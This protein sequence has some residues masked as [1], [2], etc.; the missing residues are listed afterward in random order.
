MQSV[1]ALAVQLDVLEIVLGDD[2]G[3]RRFVL[4]IDLEKFHLIGREIEEIHQ[5]EIVHAV[6]VVDQ[7]DVDYFQ[8]IVAHVERVKGEIL[9]KVERLQ[10]AVAQIDDVDV[11]KLQCRVVEIDGEVAQCRVCHGETLQMRVV[12]AWTQD[13]LIEVD[14]LAEINECQALVDVQ[15]NVVD[16]V[17]LSSFDPLKVRTR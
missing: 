2:D 6:P 17:V 13:H 15:V 11:K 12:R 9:E 1:G 16:G 5:R 3:V 8:T 10:S 14:V 7:I 4:P